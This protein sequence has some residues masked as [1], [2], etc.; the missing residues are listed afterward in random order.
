LL[1]PGDEVGESEISG[2]PINR[3]RKISAEF[4]LGNLMVEIDLGEKRVL[5]GTCNSF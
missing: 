3:R 1:C 4:C 2:A 5:V